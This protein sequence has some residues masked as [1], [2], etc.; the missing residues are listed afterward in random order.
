[1]DKTTIE[2]LQILLPHWIEH[3]KNHEAEFRKWAAAAHAEGLENLAGQ[4]DKAA[5]SMAVTDEI[6]RQTLVEAGGSNTQDEH[7]HGHDHH[8]HH[9]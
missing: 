8:H 4:L 3:N 1:M 5:S 9:E 2:K 7:H 6:L